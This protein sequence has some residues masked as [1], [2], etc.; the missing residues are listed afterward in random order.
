[1]TAIAVQVVAG[2]MT[3]LNGILMWKLSRIAK[4][5]DDRERQME[6]LDV[7]L[8]AQEE[9]CAVCRTSLLTEEKMRALLV[10][11]FQLFELRLINQGRLAPQR[12]KNDG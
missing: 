5:K 10:E 6:S 4:G 9:A 7:R 11:Q 1:M 8:K 2:L 3:L 12:R